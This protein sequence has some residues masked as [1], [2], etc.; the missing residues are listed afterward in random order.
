MVGYRL[1]SSGSELAGND[2]SSL[3]C[4]H[5]NGRETAAIYDAESNV[6]QC[7]SVDDG[8]IVDSDCDLYYGSE[9]VCGDTECLHHHSDYKASSNTQP[10][11]GHTTPPPP[12][13]TIA[14]SSNDSVIKSLSFVD[15]FLSLWIIIVMVLGV[16]VGYYSPTAQEAFNAVQITT[17]SLP[18]AMG[19]WFMMYPVLVKVRYES[20]G[21]IFRRRETYKQLAF[22]VAANWV[23]IRSV[24]TYATLHALL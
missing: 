24:M 14:P 13:T 23:S 10:D 11:A 8:P 5:R 12:N 17:V 4:R 16:V 3:R 18:V 2:K 21:A 15:R 19:L 1:H 9:L 7:K 6:V 20:F 22:S